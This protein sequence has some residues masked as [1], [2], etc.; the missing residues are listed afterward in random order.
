MSTNIIA[1]AKEGVD[2]LTET[3][4]NKF[5]FHSEFNTFKVVSTGLFEPT[6]T[7]NT[8]D[9]VE[10]TIAHGRTYAPWIIA[11]MR[12]GT[13]NG[14]VWPGNFIYGVTSYLKFDSCGADQ[15]NLIFTIANTDPINDIVAHIRWFI[16]V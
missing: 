3:D 4:P 1:V 10:Y 14:V 9:G 5:I 12:E 8:P 16:L 11:M 2:V 6:I 13:L 7:H 15:T